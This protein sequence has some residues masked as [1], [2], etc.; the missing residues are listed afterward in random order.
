MTII[1]KLEEINQKVQA[2]V[3]SKNIIAYFP[4]Q[5]NI[6]EFEHVI[7]GIGTPNI[8]LKEHINTEVLSLLRNT[9]KKLLSHPD[10]T[11]NKDYAVKSAKE[12]VDGAL[13]SLRKGCEA[14]G[15]G[16]VLLQEV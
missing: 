8:E 15:E 4:L 1:E 10:V 14:H 5:K 12:A 11:T 16:N 13:Y 2:Y 7:S 9:R 3:W 6:K